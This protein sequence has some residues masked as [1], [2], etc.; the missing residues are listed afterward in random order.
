MS[1]IPDFASNGREAV[2]K[3]KRASY[4]VILMDIQMPEMDGYTAA[5]L[6]RE[7]E[8]DRG[9]ESR[10][11]IL[12]ISAYDMDP[13]L[14]K[15]FSGY[16]V[17]PVGPADLRRAVWKAAQAKFRSEPVA[18]PR[19]KSLAERMA[20]LAPAY[21][22]SRRKEAGALEGLLRRAEFGPIERIG[23]QLRGNALSYGFPA[24]GE[25]GAELEAA[26]KARDALK[27]EAALTRI[28]GVLA[29]HVEQGS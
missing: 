23:H 10:V 20:E 6:I 15:A 24:L 2:E 16:M 5:G 8:A 28:N 12:G 3:F 11:P 18:R 29:Q 4:D 25:A 26:A 22:E 17:K 14:L 1:C 19:G 9:R 7:L 27:I 13:V 21:L